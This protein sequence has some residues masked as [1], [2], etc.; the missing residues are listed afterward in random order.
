[1]NGRSMVWPKT[2]ILT[3]FANVESKAL[4]KVSKISFQYMMKNERVLSISGMSTTSETTKSK[5]P[6]MMRLSSRPIT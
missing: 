6:W 4:G 2:K 1:M 5:R 3:A